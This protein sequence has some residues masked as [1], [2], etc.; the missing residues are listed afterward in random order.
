MA[1]SYNIGFVWQHDNDTHAVMGDPWEWDS[2]A[3]KSIVPY[4]TLHHTTTTLD[5]LTYIAIVTYCCSRL[6]HSMFVYLYL[7]DGNPASGRKHESIATSVVG[8]KH[9]ILPVHATTE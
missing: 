2:S 5:L 4:T 8:V 6:F 9:C 1:E 3:N 7:F